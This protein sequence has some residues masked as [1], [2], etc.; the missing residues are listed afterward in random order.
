MDKN[1]KHTLS[2]FALYIVSFVLPFLVHAAPL[3]LV[4]VAP[5][6]FFVEKIA[7]D[8]VQVQLM[9]P[10]GASAH[11]YEPTPRQMFSAS[12]AAIWFCTGESF[13]T[14]AVQAL[15][16]HQPKLQIIDLKKNLNLI[17]HNCTHHCCPG[18]VDLH[19]WLSARLAAQQAVTITE[20]LSSLLPENTLLYQKR[21]TAF[22]DELS[23]LDQ[24][25][26][27]ILAPLLQRHVLVSHPAYAYFCRDYNLVQH[28]IE[29]EGKDPAPQQMTALLT[30]MRPLHLKFI[31]VQPQYPHKAASL[32]AHQL[33]AELITLNP[34]A[35]DFTA[36]MLEI[37]HAF[38]RAS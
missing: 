9:V 29:I 1:F 13:E 22:Q 15:R 7:G 35:E 18:N 5:H 21:L 28:A 24:K 12:Q 33:G 11:T 2:F 37:A 32:V 38:A 19:F 36:S 27:T 34:Y 23:A 30:R 4:S 8:T 17:E 10:A 20:A 25:I 26:T 16:S 3:V 14:R 6:K 31:F